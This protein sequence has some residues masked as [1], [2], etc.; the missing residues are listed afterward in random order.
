MEKYKFRPPYQDNGRTTFPESKNRTGIYIIKEDGVIV[1]VG[2]SA[3]NLY[4][5]MYRHFQYW[6]HRW[7][8]VVSYRDRM[9]IHKYTVRIVY[10]TKKQ[11]Y[12][13]EKKLIEKYKPR[14]NDTTYEIMLQDLTPRQ[15]TYFENVTEEYFSQPVIYDLPY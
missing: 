6:H 2:Y 12:A 1:Y 13:L 8:E 3:K 11:A 7:Q 10:C 5:T 15:E 14:D 4:K 9:D